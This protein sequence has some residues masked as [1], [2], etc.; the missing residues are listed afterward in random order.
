MVLFEIVKL[1]CIKDCV[2]VSITSDENAIC[3]EIYYADYYS[4]ENSFISIRKENKEWVG[5]FYKDCFLT[6]SQYREYII[7]KILGND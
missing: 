5:L 4:D 7:D 3:G 2:T 1:Y 6:E